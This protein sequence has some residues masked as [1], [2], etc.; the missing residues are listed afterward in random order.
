MKT[1]LVT[2]AHIRQA[3][4]CTGG[5]RNWFNRHGFSWNDFVTNG[6]AAEQLEATGDPLALQAAAIARQE[7]ENG[8][9]G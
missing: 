1:V 8:R 9:R 4:L 6:I 2:V 3:K 5:A 7:A